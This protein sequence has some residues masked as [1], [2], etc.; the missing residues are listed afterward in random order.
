M[1]NTVNVYVQDAFGGRVYGILTMSRVPCVGEWISVSHTD[2][3]VVR[4]VHRHG[5]SVV[6]EA[7]TIYTRE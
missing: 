3:E 2:L 6:G 5:S 7:A 1:S 4:V